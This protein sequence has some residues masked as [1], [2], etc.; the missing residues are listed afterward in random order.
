MGGSLN[1]LVHHEGAHESA[2]I[3]TGSFDRIN[4]IRNKANGMRKISGLKPTSYRGRAMSLAVAG[5]SM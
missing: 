1:I 3:D 4:R 5:N 2:Y